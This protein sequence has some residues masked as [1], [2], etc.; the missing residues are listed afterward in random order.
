MRVEIALRFLSCIGLGLGEEEPTKRDVYG[1][2]LAG[3]RFRVNNAGRYNLLHG[4]SK[5]PALRRGDRAT[6]LFR[7]GDVI[8]TRV[9]K[10]R[11]SWSRCRQPGPVRWFGPS[12][13]GAI[14][15]SSAVLIG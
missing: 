1:S 13:G 14:F 7:D 6:C 12:G 15:T 10:R 11:I 2:S 3:E 8:V 4:P 9:P 5:S